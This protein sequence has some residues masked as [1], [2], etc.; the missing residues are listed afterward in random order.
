[1]KLECIKK[2]LKV[3]KFLILFYVKKE[4]WIISA[5][6]LA[7]FLCLMDFLKL[8]GLDLYLDRIFQWQF[9]ADADY[10]IGVLFLKSVYSLN[11]LF[12]FI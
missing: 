10:V 4:T 12:R 3:Q 8:S 11:E 5:F 6:F 7:Q 1:M 2:N 9:T